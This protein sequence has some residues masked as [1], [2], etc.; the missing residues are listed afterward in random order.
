MCNLEAL[1]GEWES[2]QLRWGG[3]PSVLQELTS[4]IKEKTAMDQKPQN[5][6][7]DLVITGSP[8]QAKADISFPSVEDL[9][10]VFSSSIYLCICFYRHETCLSIFKH[11]LRFK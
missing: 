5:L 10:Y 6:N 11:I 4:P 2:T 1:E 9:I 7:Y 8:G 3:L